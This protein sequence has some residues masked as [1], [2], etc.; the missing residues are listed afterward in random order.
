MQSCNVNHN[1]INST[2]PCKGQFN[3]G[4]DTQTGNTITKTTDS[5]IS[6][7]C[8]LRSLNYRLLKKEK[9]KEQKKEEKEE[10]K[11]Q[12]TIKR[13]RWERKRRK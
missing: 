12:K 7:M 5:S 4:V 2:E 13:R 1:A 6:S 11:L 10:D 3:A 9:K 8:K